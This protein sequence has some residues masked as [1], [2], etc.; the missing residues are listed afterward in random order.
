MNLTTSKLKVSINSKDAVLVSYSCYNK[1][2]Q[3]G[4]LKNNRNLLSHSLRDYK[5]EVKVS[6]GPT[7]ETCRGKNPSF[8]LLVP[9]VCQ[10]SLAF[11]ACRCI[12]P[13]SSFIIIWPSSPCVSLSSHGVFLFF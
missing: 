4:W 12:T 3:H 13:I 10:Q 5:S 7:S 9:D 8:L 6:A 2:P 11:L 1:V